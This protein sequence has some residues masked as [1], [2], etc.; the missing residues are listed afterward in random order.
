[1]DLL[2]RDSSRGA[3]RQYCGARNIATL[4]SYWLGAPQDDVVDQA[5]IECGTTGK[6]LQ[7]LR[8]QL[9]GGNLMQSPIGAASTAG[10][11]H[12]VVR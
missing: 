10:C 3:G 4:L 6:G 11:S 8:G 2:S 1:M 9:Y 5:R 7:S 12:V